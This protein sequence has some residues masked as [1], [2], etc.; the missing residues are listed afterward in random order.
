MTERVYNFSPGPAVLPLSVLEQVQREMLALPGV[1]SSILEISH[2]SKAFLAILAEAEANLRRLLG[3]G[4]NY[5]VLFLQGGARLQFSMIPMNLLRDS[6]KTAEY[7]VSGSWGEKAAQE[8]TLEGEARVTWSGKATNYDRLPAWSEVPRDPTAAYVHITSNETIQG[9]QFAA[10]PD[11][12]GVP[13]VCDA[14]SD[15]L[16]R[17]V[18]IDR[19]GV[20]YACAQKNAGPSGVTIVVIREDLLDRAPKSVPSM[21]NYAAY[22]KENSMQNTPNTFGIYVFMLI[23]RWLENDIGGLAKMLEVNRAKARLIYDALDESGGFYRGHAQ[24]DCRSLMNVTFNMPNDEVQK[25]F[26]SEAAEQNL[27][28]LKGH[29]SVGGIRASIYNAMPMDGAR[30]LAEFMRDFCRRNG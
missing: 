20:F 12:G 29:R 3:I 6:G 22:A 30:K 15:F 21:L 27:C 28:E 5:K 11:A 1:G 8:A 17:P 4:D 18:D 16:H 10:D 25:R 7:V 2:R 19:Y 23:T 13:L 24:Q 26:L 14:S 9:V